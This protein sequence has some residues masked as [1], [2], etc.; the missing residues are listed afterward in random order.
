MF[1]LRLQKRSS[2][3]AFVSIW[4][5]SSGSWLH[6]W[7]LGLAYFKLMSNV[8]QRKTPLEECSSEATRLNQARLDGLQGATWYAKKKSSV[9][10]TISSKIIKSANWTIEPRKRDLKI[11]YRIR[12]GSIWNAQK[13]EVHF[14]SSFMIVF[15]LPWSHFKRQPV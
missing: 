2:R 8:Q 14:H 5:L 15:I 3:L 9:K 12:Q 10:A 7:C 4:I 1:L 11:L 6:S 13:T